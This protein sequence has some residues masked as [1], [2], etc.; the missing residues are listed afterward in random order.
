MDQRNDGMTD[1][2]TDVWMDGRMYRPSC[3]AVMTPLKIYLH[4]NEQSDFKVIEHKDDV[5][6]FTIPTPIFDFVLT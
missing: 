6:L 5:D 2:G 1:R 4:Q 3:G